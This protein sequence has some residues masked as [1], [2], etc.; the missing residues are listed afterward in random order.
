MRQKPSARVQNFLTNQIKVKNS[1][2]EEGN[3]RIGSDFKVILCTISLENRM[4]HNNNK[5]MYGI[6]VM[7]MK[8]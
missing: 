7:V 5:I 4:V 3:C 8:G 6:M 2:S 1:K